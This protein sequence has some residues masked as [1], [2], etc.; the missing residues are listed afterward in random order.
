M[1]VTTGSEG[2]L[3]AG[4]STPSRA[5]SPDPDR[6]WPRSAPAALAEHPAIA[7]L[8]A[9]VLPEVMRE[10]IRAHAKHGSRSM[11][12]NPAGRLAHL[13]EEV[14]E[15]AR[16]LSEL[17]QLGT[18]SRPGVGVGAR[19]RLRRELRAELIQVAHVAAAWAACL[20][21]ERGPS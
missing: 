13:V 8:R 6:P 21:L 18:E 20:D 16:P 15:V 1:T 3:I 14:G 9:V 2:C 17:D 12:D 4:Q 10:A 11:L 7:H 5:A 19:E